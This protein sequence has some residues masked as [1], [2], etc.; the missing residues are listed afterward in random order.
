MEG[1]KS[2]ASKNTSNYI[3]IASRH[4]ATEHRASTR[5]LH[6]TPFLASVLISVQ[7]FST[8]L[9]SSSTVLRHLFPGLPL[10]RLPWEFHSR[11]CLAI[12]S[13]GFRSLWAG[14]PHLR[15]L[16]RKSILSCFVRFHSSPF[17]MWSGQKNLNIFLRHLLIKIGS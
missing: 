2:G 17:V 1:F 3:H 4:S 5:I 15:F 10:P 8:L 12:S 7:V 13:D 14:H 9:A 11:A 16:I 6:L